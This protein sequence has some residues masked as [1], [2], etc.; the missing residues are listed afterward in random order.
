MR[1]NIIIGLISAIIGGI[2]G[3]WHLK[4]EYKQELVIKAYSD[5]IHSWARNSKFAEDY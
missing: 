2:L 3:C 1:Q 5:F 4:Q